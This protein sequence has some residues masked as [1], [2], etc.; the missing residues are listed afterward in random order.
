M[1]VELDPAIRL[2]L[3]GTG[4]ATWPARKG[5]SSECPFRV[6]LLVGRD[7]AVSLGRLA[8]DTW[9]DTPA[10]GATGCATGPA[11]DT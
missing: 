9:G 3:T 4:S 1:E 2:C 10:P 6:R 7:H 8:E 11:R 5:H